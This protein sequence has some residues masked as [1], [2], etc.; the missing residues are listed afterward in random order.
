ML[1]RSTRQYSTDA[2]FA[3]TGKTWRE[4]RTLLDA[5]VKSKKRFDVTTTYLIRQHGLSPIW[6]QAVA[7]RYA[8]DLL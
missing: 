3:S 7:L 1:A 2:V 5:W 4:W 6:A 8:L